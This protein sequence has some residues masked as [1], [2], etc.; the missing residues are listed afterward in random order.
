MSISY[1]GVVGHKSKVTLPSVETWGS[2][3]NI[4]RDPPRS[5]QTRKIDKVGETSEIT[6]MI[7]ESGDRACEAIM[8]YARGVNPMVA[9]SYSNAG[10]NGGQRVNG[11]R[12]GGNTGRNANNAQAYLPYRIMNGGAFRPPARSQRELMPLSRLPRVWTSAFTQP[13]FVDY[14]KRAQC[15]S[16]SADAQTVSRM[17]PL[18]ACA[19]P[20]ATYKIETPIS[21]PFEVRYVIKNP[22]LVEGFS[23][24]KP[25]AVLGV[26]MGDITQEIVDKPVHANAQMNMG[27][28]RMQKDIDLS[29]LD[30]HQYVQDTP[31]H[32]NANAN[33]SQNIQ[34]TSIDELF[35]VDTDS[36]IK[37]QLNISYD[38][39]KIGYSKHDYIHDDPELARNLPY[40]QASTNIGQT[41]VYHR[42]VSDPVQERKY[43]SNRPLASATTNRGARHQTVNNISSRH[44]NLKPTVT[45]GGYVP[46][47]SRPMVTHE[48]HLTQ[49]D[50]ER[51]KM[52]QKI[53]EMQQG[54]YG[55]TETNP[56]R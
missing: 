20:T 18:R 27:A 26:E 37:N 24:I 30:T 19:R 47:A 35:T 34:S 28:T 33:Y 41:E 23:G 6:Q 43:T 36:N 8:T 5:I 11:F 32:A 21:E 2:N 49:F 1:H 17:E 53:Y 52:R 31:L 42:A 54:R 55:A 45:P 14:S 44:Y 38:V 29:H 51:T 16:G 40:H 7:Q 39:N 10:N 15:G 9:V 56:Y 25:Q 48:N 4:L 50:T 3:M 12:T 13:G 46:N 22:T